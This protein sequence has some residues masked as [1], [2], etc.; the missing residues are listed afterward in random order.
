VPKS[1]YRDE[2]PFAKY[3]LDHIMRHQFL[4][5]VIEWRIG[6]QNDWSVNPGVCGKRF[7][8]Y[9]DPTTWTELESTYA[10]AGIEENIAAF[11]RMIA[12]F[13]RLARELAC[14]LGYSY[15]EELDKN[16]TAYCSNILD[17][18]PARGIDEPA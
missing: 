3:M 9:L 11:N 7:K 1:L 5:R 8:R 4:H 6:S 15:P 2:L 13:R 14:E 18:I 17:R 12:L 10:G 16:V